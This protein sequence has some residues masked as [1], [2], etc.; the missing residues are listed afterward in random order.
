MSGNRNILRTSAA[1][2]AL[3]L[4][5]WGASPSAITPAAAQTVEL[6]SIADLPEW[7]AGVGR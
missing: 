6:P 2:F 4:V 1:A 7:L 3:G 5:M